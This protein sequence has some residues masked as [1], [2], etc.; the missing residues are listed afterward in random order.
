MNILPKSGSQISI[1]QVKGTFWVPA[2]SSLDNTV[3]VKDALTQSIVVDDYPEMDVPIPSAITNITRISYQWTGWP[4][5]QIATLVVQPV[6]SYTDLTGVYSNQAFDGKRVY[7]EFT[8][9]NIKS[10]LDY[11]NPNS[12]L[13]NVSDCTISTIRQAGG[14]SQYS[15]ISIGEVTSFKKITTLTAPLGTYPLT[16]TLVAGFG[17]V[18][19]QTSE[20]VNRL[21]TTK[22]RVNLSTIKTVFYQVN[23]GT[24]SDWGQPPDA[25]HGAGDENLYFE[26]SVDGITWTI[27]DT[28]L[29]NIAANTWNIRTVNIPVA[30]QVSTG[31]FLRFRQPSTGGGTATT[32]FAGYRDTWAVTNVYASNT[33]YGVLVANDYAGC[34]GI[35]TGNTWLAYYNNGKISVLSAP[36][37]PSPETVKANKSSWVVGDTIGIVIDDTIKYAFIYKN[38]ILQYT[39]QYTGTD[40]RAIIAQGPGRT[41]EGNI[42]FGETGFKYSDYDNLIH[43]KDSHPYGSIQASKTY[44]ANFKPVYQ[45]RDL[46]SFGTISSRLSTYY[47]VVDDIPHRG[48]IT[49]SDFHSKYLQSYHLIKFDKAGTHKY[50]V[51]PGCTSLVATIIGAGG[52]GGAGGITWESPIDPLI[53]YDYDSTWAKLMTWYPNIAGG[54]GGGA[55]EVKEDV[56]I[57]TRGADSAIVTIGLG[58]AGGDSYMEDSV[59]L[60]I[61]DGKGGQASSLTIG[62]TSVVSSGGFG[63][64]SPSSWHL[65]YNEYSS[66]EW[67]LQAN[68]NNRTVT[69]WNELTANTLV[70]GGSPG[71]SVDKSGSGSSGSS[72]R[73]YSETAQNTW[74]WSDYRPS[75]TNIPHINNGIQTFYT[76]TSTAGIFARH[77]GIGGVGGGNKFFKGG[78]SGISNTKVAAWFDDYAKVNISSGLLIES[79]RNGQNGGGGAG[80]HSGS[81]YSELAWWWDADL[82]FSSKK[83][84]SYLRGIVGHKK[85][86][87]L[88]TTQTITVPSDGTAEMVCWG[89]GGGGGGGYGYWQWYGGGGKAGKKSATLSF[90][91][92]PGNTIT[93]SIGQGG[94]GGNNSHYDGYPGTNTTVSLN[95]AVKIT[96]LGGAGG[97]KTSENKNN[98]GEDSEIGVGGRHYWYHWYWWNWDYYY[99]Y[100]YSWYWGYN[101]YH[102]Y[103]WWY[104]YYDGWWWPGYWWHGHNTPAGLA[105]GGAG[106]HYWWNY[107]WNNTSIRSGGNGFARVTLTTYPGNLGNATL[108]KPGGTVLFNSGIYPQL[109]NCKNANVES[110]AGDLILVGSGVT[111]AQLTAMG[112]QTSLAGLT[113]IAAGDVLRV[114]V[115]GKA[116]E[117]LDIGYWIWNAATGPVNSGQVYLFR[118]VYTTPGFESFSYNTNFV[119]PATFTANQVLV[120]GIGDRGTKGLLGVNFEITATSA[121]FNPALTKNEA[122][123]SSQDGGDGGDGYVKIS[124]WN[125]ESETESYFIVPVGITSLKLT[126]GSNTTTVTGLLPSEAILVSRS[127]IVGTHSYIS[128]DVTD[129]HG[130]KIILL[131]GTDLNGQENVSI[132]LV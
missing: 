128:R 121:T 93:A 107:Y 111:Q 78:S 98:Y 31:V 110:P 41:L 53:K 18:S 112:I 39:Y 77:I 34:V 19:Q 40:I 44:D 14:V 89:A 123:I 65:R 122:L 90:D 84:I 2:D 20:P 23:R 79:Q 27:L 81:G 64:R 109:K 88:Y 82:T 100:D 46:D 66:K 75:T 60:T 22:T 67:E 3:Y 85:V 15:Q 59:S 45:T 87:D 71:G 69:E 95:G 102:Y 38:N 28:V 32:V 17:A 33:T 57:L 68:V 9:S 43:N 29:Y 132:E 114:K 49:L 101:Y 129:I 127:G 47:G 16:S 10:A 6:D 1:G 116:N 115:N 54:G 12:T 5:R 86:Y 52:G 37:E 42:N 124:K 130:G 117:A 119:V 91:V 4:K 105:A 113:K 63:G 106:S 126:V 99:W 125:Y 36:P 120:F 76:D 104:G 103:Y 13:L 30:A 25:N 61:S 80:G 8:P 58:G 50:N 131:T 92:A 24:A 55:G 26:Y 48:L 35:K 56:T 11:I 97:I 62:G 7:F 96:G 51:P 21:L 70:S 83:V 72:F 108:T 74:T 118:N 73:I 94:A